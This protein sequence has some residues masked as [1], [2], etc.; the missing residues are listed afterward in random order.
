MF[1]QLFIKGVKRSTI[2]VERSVLDNYLHVHLVL[3][4]LDFIMNSIERVFRTVKLD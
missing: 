3:L 4:S 1:V 2:N